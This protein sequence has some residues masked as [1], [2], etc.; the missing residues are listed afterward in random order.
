M[1]TIT[2]AQLNQTRHGDYTHEQMLLLPITELKRLCDVGYNEQAAPY[3]RDKL[4]AMY[5]A[6]LTHAEILRMTGHLHKKQNLEELYE[7]NLY[8]DL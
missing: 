7:L 6:G 4:I 1:A 3:L 5:N 2:Q 8:C